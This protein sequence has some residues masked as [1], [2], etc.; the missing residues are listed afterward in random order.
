ME[1]MQLEHFIAVCDEGTFT[2]AAERVFRTQSAVS[3]SIKRLEEETGTRLLARGVHDVTPTDAGK[4]V[5]DYARRI[6]KLRD[7]ST[8]QVEALKNLDA[9]SLA[10]GAHEAAAM[11]LLPGPLKQYL[12]AFPDIRL[13]IYRSRLEEIPSQI[14]DREL[15]LGFVKEEPAVHGLDVIQVHTDEMVLIAHPQHRLTRCGSVQIQ[16][17]GRESFVFHHHCAATSRSILKLF[18]QYS[19]PFRIV[20]ELWSFENVKS[21]VCEGVGLAIVPRIIAEAEL[22]EG[23]LVEIPV[24]ELHI[25]R[26]TLM[27]FR[28]QGDVSEPARQLINMICT[29][30]QKNANSPQLVGHGLAKCR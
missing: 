28:D 4:V 21:F 1:F 25:P 24:E 14:L 13:G 16:D 6:V 9:G 12:Q 20:A 7:E 18:E 19:T 8:R 11:Y 2:R 3:Q 30:Y 23:R 27:I 10:L 22:R 5:L 29:Y 26:P 17:L 15:D